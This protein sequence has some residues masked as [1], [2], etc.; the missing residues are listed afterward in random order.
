M[1]MS[2]VR[3]AELMGEAV[4]TGVQVSMPDLARPQSQASRLM[5][6]VQ[7]SKHRPV[8]TLD[9]GAGQEPYLCWLVHR[10]CSVN[11]VAG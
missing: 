11:R 6:A 3:P 9:G 7:G 2:Q 5:W 4:Q 10:R 1:A 8:D